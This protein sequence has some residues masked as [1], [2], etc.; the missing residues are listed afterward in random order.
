M[1]GINVNL[2]CV[3]SWIWPIVD[4]IVV[5]SFFLS[6]LLLLGEILNGLMVLLLHAQFLCA[7]N[8]EVIST[9]ATD[10]WKLLIWS[11]LMTLII[12]FH[13]SRLYYF[14]TTFLD[15]IYCRKSVELLIAFYSKYFSIK[16]LINGRRR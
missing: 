13:F 12:R 5:E 14:Y 3:R 10:A 11:Q 4:Q 8:W 9:V 2:I 1:Y 15:L 7:I 16:L 6:L